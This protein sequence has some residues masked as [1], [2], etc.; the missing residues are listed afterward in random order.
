MDSFKE[1]VAAQGRRGGSFTRLHVP[2]YFPVSLRIAF[3]RARLNSL[4]L[5]IIRK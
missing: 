5:F 4:D 2:V 3:C 1:G